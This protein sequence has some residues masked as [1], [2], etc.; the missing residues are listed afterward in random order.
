MHFGAVYMSTVG[1]GLIV[2]APKGSKLPI[3]TTM[4]SQFS[5]AMQLNGRNLMVNAPANSTLK[6]FGVNGKLCLKEKVGANSSVSLEKIPAGK[7][8]A[9]VVSSQGKT[10]SSTAL[11]VK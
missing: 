11:V 4:R 7:W 10:L 5:I 1:R 3:P 6:L 9:K 8:M 2:G